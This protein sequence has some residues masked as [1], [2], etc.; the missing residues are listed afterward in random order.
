[1]VC[2][3]RPRDQQA[4]RQ[5]HLRREGHTP[6]TSRIASCQPTRGQD[7]ISVLE[8]EVELR[9][10]TGEAGCGDKT[11]LSRPNCYLALV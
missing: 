11:A 5:L 2:L 10:V 4:D 8:D 6:R 9:G 3:N 7:G 1:M